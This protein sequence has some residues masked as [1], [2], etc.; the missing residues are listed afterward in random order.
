MEEQDSLENYLSEDEFK[1]FMDKTLKSCEEQV[2]NNLYASY[3]LMMSMFMGS[4]IKAKVPHDRF[5]QDLTEILETIGNAL[6][7]AQQYKEN[8]NKW[9]RH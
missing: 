2:D 3:R 4:M 5:I 9:K 8:E 6:Q 7:I 1:K